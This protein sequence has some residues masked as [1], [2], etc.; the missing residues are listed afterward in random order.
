[1]PVLF[2]LSPSLP[3]ISDHILC[4]PRRARCPY[5][6]LSGPACPSS[7]RSDPYLDNNNPIVPQAFTGSSHKSSWQERGTIL[8]P[9]ALSWPRAGG[10]LCCPDRLQSM[11][12]H[13]QPQACQERMLGSRVRVMQQKDPPCLLGFLLGKPDASNHPNPSPCFSTPPTWDA[14]DS[15]VAQKGGWPLGMGEAPVAPPDT[16]GRPRAGIQ[17]PP[18]GKLTCSSIRRIWTSTI[19][20][21]TP[22]LP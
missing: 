18:G 1:M 14:L 4:S 6:G 8:V 19:L 21:L 12:L 9:R 22:S 10:Q 11:A 15:P 7:P 5:T 16:R 3:S 13:P 17:D 20:G 2:P